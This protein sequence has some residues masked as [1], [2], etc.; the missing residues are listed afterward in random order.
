MA[1]G[2]G[3]DCKANT[4]WLEE[5][6]AFYAIACGDGEPLADDMVEYA[7]YMEGLAEISTLAAPLWGAHHLK[8]M[9]WQIRAKWRY[10]GAFAGKTAHPLL[11]IS[12]QFDPVCPLHDA[13]AVQARYEGAGLLVQKS[14]GH[15]SISSP[16]LCTAKNVRAYFVNGTVPAEGTECDVDELP[17]GIET[18]GRKVSAFS[19]EDRELK[20]ALDDLVDAV[21]RF[22]N[23]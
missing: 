14:Y 18:G 11:V 17:F 9:Q 3:C 23:L 10:T 4:P 21:P 12:P 22:G 15:C 7:R 5:N 6:E 8:C 16:S 19:S 2:V 13:R 20:G 1:N